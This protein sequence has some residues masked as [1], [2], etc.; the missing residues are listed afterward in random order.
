MKI[1][2]PLRSELFNHIPEVSDAFVS[3]TAVF[4]V[5]PKNQFK[6]Q[7]VSNPT[8]WFQNS[9]PRSAWINP[10]TTKKTCPH[11]FNSTKA[12]V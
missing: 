5:N 1:Q 8:P 2:D 10:K 9:E 7:S 6:S 12:K 3:L 4:Q 11:R